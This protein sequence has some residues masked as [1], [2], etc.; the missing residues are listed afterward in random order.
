MD[1]NKS[2]TANFS[3]LCYTLT[4]SANPANGGSVSPSAS[5]C[6]GGKYAHGTTV[7][8]T[9]N[10]NPGYSFTSWTGATGDNPTTITMTGDRSVTANF[11]IQCYDLTVTSNPNEGGSV[12]KTPPNC[13]TQY[14][15]GTTVNLTA[16][17]QTGYTFVNWTGPVANA[18]SASTTV[19]MDGHKSVT[20]NFTK[21]CYTLTTNASPSE[22]GSITRDP[23]ADCPDGKYSHGTVVSLTAVANP[24][25]TFTGWGGDNESENNPTTVT[26]TANR[27]VTANFT[28]KC[29]SLTTAVSPTNS[30]TVSAD[31]APNCGTLYRH[32]TNVSLNATPSDGYNFSSWSGITGSSINPVTIQMDGA[33]SVTANFTQNCYTLTTVISPNGTGTISAN[34]APTCNGNT[35]YPEGAQVELTAV[36]ATGYTLL[37]WSG[38]STAN[39]YTV[40]MTSDK[41]VTANFT[42]LCYTLTTGV[43]PDDSG[44]VTVN[45]NTNCT[46]G[47]T[48]GT[49]VSITAVP[50]TGYSFASW[51]GATG[52]S[53]TTVTMTGNRSV[54]ANFDPLCY[55]L[56]TAASPTGGGTVSASPPPNCGAQYTHG[57]SVQLTANPAAG[58]GFASWS[59]AVTGSA[60]PTTIVMNGA[61]SVTATFTQS[62]YTLTTA[63]LPAGQGTVSASPPPNCGA[64]YTH[65]TIVNLT[66]T[67]SS[68]YSFLNWTGDASGTAN[69]TP[70]TMTAARSVTAN[71]GPNNPVP[72]LAS[73]DPDKAATGSP[74]LLVTLTGAGFIPTSVVRWNG[75]DLSGAQTISSTEIRVTVPA[76]LLVNPGAGSILVY[77]PG[78]GGGTSNA[79]LLTLEPKVVDYTVYLPY[80]TR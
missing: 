75:S 58:Y 31:P 55:S 1:G 27:T 39:P 20:A 16:S 43:S 15:Y 21:V 49:V 56:T 73:I 26:M 7:T 32:G 2:V 80:T 79:L 68:G 36:P 29:Y 23:S 17:P 3:I 45:T 44:E 8:L 4:T 78:P 65:G 48:H 24:S 38:G 35:Q 50:A 47:Y 12:T 66:A 5:N 77:N 76:A 6:D 67:A 46:G 71:F 61:K 60:N 40:T 14:S 62:C 22:G 74:D 19:L 54:T 70:V 18:T 51:T 52:G 63:V 13:G 64:Q 42:Q 30:G 9:A 72:T 33:K 53:T 59:G 34:V 41:T 69:P 37:N 10:P 28:I 11:T 57:T 25:H